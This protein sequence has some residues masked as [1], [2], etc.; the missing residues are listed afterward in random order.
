MQRFAVC[1]FS[2]DKRDAPDFL[3][4]AVT[5]EIAGENGIANLPVGGDGGIEKVRGFDG[6]VQRRVTDRKCDGQVGGIAQGN[7]IYR[8]A[9]NGQVAGAVS[10]AAQC[11]TLR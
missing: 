5:V 11:V 10:R 1:F 3:L 6:T 9:R 7:R 8:S 2:R 4:F